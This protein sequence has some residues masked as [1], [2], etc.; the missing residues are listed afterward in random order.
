MSDLEFGEL[1]AIVGRGFQ[2]AWVD[3]ATS[4][5]ARPGEWAKIATKPN[6]AAAHMMANHI[7]NGVLKAF[8]P[9]GEFEATSRGCD[10]WA[11]YVGEQS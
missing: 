9:P 11:R 2:T 3:V 4:L 8:R 6:P 5:R 1:P 10:T 7:S